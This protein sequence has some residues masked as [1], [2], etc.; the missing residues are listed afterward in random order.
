MPAGSSKFP[1]SAIPPAERFRELPRIPLLFARAAR[2]IHVCLVRRLQTG[3][4]DRG[5]RSPQPGFE[6]YCADHEGP[7]RFREIRH[8]PVRR[9]HRTVTTELRCQALDN[10]VGPFPAPGIHH[11]DPATVLAMLRAEALLPPVKDHRDR[12]RLSLPVGGQ[13]PNQSFASGFS[14]PAGRAADLSSCS[15]QVV[16]VN[17]QMKGHAPAL[18]EPQPLSIAPEA[19]S[20]V[21]PLD[22]P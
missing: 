21:L 18:S 3:P 5:R 10:L 16:S 22:N 12:M 1:E 4:R 9:H 2:H 8:L 15:E 14:I 20:G 13:L 17:D 19:A 11:L 6:L 7:L